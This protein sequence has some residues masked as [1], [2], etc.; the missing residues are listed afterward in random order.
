[1]YIWQHPDWPH[2]TW[3]AA[4]L[5]A[6]VKSL[7]Q[8]QARLLGKMASLPVE[9]DRDA[10]MDALIQNAIRTSEIEGEH[11]DVE[12]VRSS[13]ARRLGLLRAGQ[14]HR[15]RST[16]RSSRVRGTNEQTGLLPHGRLQDRDCPADNSGYNKPATRW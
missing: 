2:F 4:T 12:S 14:V 6:R 11:L 1:M 5:E 16:K 9:V 8:L 10:Q 15:K 3:Q 13:V 7:G